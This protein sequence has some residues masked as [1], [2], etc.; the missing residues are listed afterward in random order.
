MART[1]TSNTTTAALAANVPAVDAPDAPAKPKPRPLNAAQ[2]AA[3]IAAAAEL[4][5]V[6]PKKAVTNDVPAKPANDKAKTKGK[7]SKTPETAKA[8]APVAAPAQPLQARNMNVGPAPNIKQSKEYLELLAELDSFKKTL[9]AAPAAPADPL[10]PA[11]P[12]QDYGNLQAAMGLANNRKLYVSLRESVR[13]ELKKRAIY[14]KQ[15][16][17]ALSVAQISDFITVL[18]HNRPEFKRYVNGWPIT[19]IARTALKNRRGYGSQIERG[20]VKNPKRLHEKLARSA[21]NEVEGGSVGDGNEG[22]SEGGVVDDEDEGATETNGEGGVAEREGDGDESD[23]IA[24]EHQKRNKPA[25]RM[26]EEVYDVSESDDEA[27]STEGDEVVVDVGGGVGN[28]VEEAE[29][30]DV[31]LKR[32]SNSKAKGKAKAVMQDDDFEMEDVEEEIPTKGQKRKGS[33]EKTRSVKRVK[34]GSK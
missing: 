2:R 18:K 25:P 32:R 15:Q 20:V 24:A 30:V 26:V 27:A 12:N 13:D 33:N 34:A 17:A 4:G 3:R 16:Y 1:T 23:G 8:A 5:A 9:A 19:E 7:T 22:N 6:L 11:P 21:E 10:I 28:E 29:D 14:D 31:P